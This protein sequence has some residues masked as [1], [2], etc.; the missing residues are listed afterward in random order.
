M[1]KQ[2]SPVLLRAVSREKRT[3]LTSVS[4]VDPVTRPLKRNYACSAKASGTAKN[5]DTGFSSITEVV[6]TC[7]MVER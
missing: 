6:L 4:N 5:V 7:R 2:D 3:D 1:L